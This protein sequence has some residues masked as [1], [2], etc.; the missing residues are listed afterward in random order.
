MY[1]TSVTPYTWYDDSDKCTEV[2]LTKGR[3]TPTVHAGVE[4]GFI[5][6]VF[7]IFKSSSKTCD[8]SEEMKSE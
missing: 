2:P 1:I 8:C 3:A 4:I 5:T 6:N 7:L